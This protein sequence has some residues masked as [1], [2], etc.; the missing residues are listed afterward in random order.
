[1]AIDVSLEFEQAPR[2]RVEV[3][4]YRSA[5]DFLRETLNRAD[6]YRSRLRTAIAAGRAEANRGDLVDGEEVF[7]RLDAELD[8]NA[9]HS[10]KG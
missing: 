4:H 8:D 9:K 2:R 1:M 5:E 7:E 10:G 6:E 3:G